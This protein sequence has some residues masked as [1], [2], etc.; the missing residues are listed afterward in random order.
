MK[1]LAKS[2]LLLASPLV[3]SATE[4]MNWQ[5]VRVADTVALTQG[6]SLKSA[7]GEAIELAADTKW[8][9][10]ETF[11]LPSLPAIDIVLVAKGCEQPERESGMELVLPAGARERSEVGVQLSRE[12]R[13]EIFIETK[14]FSGRSFL[15]AAE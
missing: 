14:D 6:L 8:L 11:P 3:A 2:L 1:L 7:S 15:R 12:C 5:D 9:V 13:L 10:E 4:P